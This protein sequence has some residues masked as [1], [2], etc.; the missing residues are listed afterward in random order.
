M[1]IDVNAIY[2]LNT[3][4]QGSTMW[5]DLTGKARASPISWYPV[6]I[7]VVAFAPNPTGILFKKAFVHLE[8]NKLWEKQLIYSYLSQ[9]LTILDKQRLILKLVGRKIS[10]H[11]HAYDPPEEFLKPLTFP[12]HMRKG[13]AEGASERR[14]PIL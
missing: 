6:P 1:I 10:T 7:P 9:Y 4:S 5:S 11:A 13:W 12:S 2:A 8:L 3:K 14:D